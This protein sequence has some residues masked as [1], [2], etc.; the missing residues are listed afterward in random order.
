MRINPLT[1]QP[2]SKPADFPK[3]NQ[4]VIVPG[5]FNPTRYYNKSEVDALLANFTPSGGGA[6]SSVFTRIGDVVAQSGDYTASLITTVASGTLAATNVQTAL[7]ELNIEKQNVI[8]LGTTSQ[9]FRGDLSL[10][11][12][13]T[14][15]SS[16]TNDAGYLSSISGQ[17]HGLLAGLTDDDHTQ[18]LSLAGRSGTTNNP[19]LSTT[20]SGQLNF[21]TAS[22]YG[23]ILSSTTHS[24]KGK[25]QFGLGLP[26]VFDE[27]NS[28]WGVGIANPT[29]PLTLR[30]DP[31]DTSSGSVRGYFGTVQPNPAANSAKSFFANDN[32]LTVAAGGSVNYTGSLIGGRY[33]VQ[34]LTNGAATTLNGLLLQAFIG[35][36]FGAPNSTGVGTTTTGAQIQVN[37]KSNFVGTSAVDQVGGYFFSG[38]FSP[39]NITRMTGAHLAIG[40]STAGAGVGTIA[41]AIAARIGR[42]NP[43]GVNSL[44]GGTLTNSYM[45]YIDGWPTGPTYTNTPVQLELE[46]ND[47]TAI[48]IRQQDTAATNLFGGRMT[49]GAVAAPETSAVLDLQST[50][51]ALIVS[52]M[53]TTQRDALTAV[54]GMIIY[55]STTA[56]FNFRENGAWVTGSGLI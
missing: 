47:V 6:V 3:P 23:G 27:V 42:R 9:Y 33:L 26:N 41:T 30:S 51:G 18:Y 11:T 7:N 40:A 24:S 15:V 38:S 16:F 37:N 28:R 43:Q 22:G 12:F 46:D 48:A 34:Y 49:I 56:A 8:T 14:A 13:P 44:S 2:K 50:T 10:A 55:N 19:T 4:T 36:I 54:N 39:S 31:T 25:I 20:T 29:D 53:T 21:T 45:A 52:R 35:P 1:G 5:G 17:D 32:F